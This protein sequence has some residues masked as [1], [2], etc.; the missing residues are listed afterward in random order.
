MIANHLLAVSSSLAYQAL[1]MRQMEG[2]SQS[3]APE[4]NPSL[5]RSQKLGYPSAAAV[6][7]PLASDAVPSWRKEKTTAL[8][9]D[10][11]RKQPRFSDIYTTQFS[12]SSA[13]FAQAFNTEKQEEYTPSIS[14]P[15]QHEALLIHSS[16]LTGRASATPSA[17]RAAADEFAL[18]RSSYAKSTEFFR[19]AFAPA[20][21][22]S[23]LE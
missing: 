18:A 12:F 13:A 20:P 1:A 10:K 11:P 14:P 4:P 6:Q 15:V 23:L 9:E 3:F 2:G 7:L 19:A 21:I 5:K 17:Q 22:I 16:S 8:T